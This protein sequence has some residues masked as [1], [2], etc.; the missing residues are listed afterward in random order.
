MRILSRTLI[1][2]SVLFG[3]ACLM[4]LSRASAA[5]KA[6]C[7]NKYQVT[8][9]VD[10]NG[11][12]TVEPSHATDSQIDEWLRRAGVT[13]HPECYQIRTY[14]NHKLK[15]K[16]GTLPAMQC[17]N[18]TGP[19]SKQVRM[20]QPGG[21]GKTQRVMFNTSEAAKVVDAEIKSAK[22]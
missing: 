20:M 22:K 2:V 15:Y 3:V 9:G 10:A 4:M 6:R 13:D 1:T 7:Q 11:C 14:E 19:Q 12:E 21:S 5:D 16:K 17:I 18:K 8:F